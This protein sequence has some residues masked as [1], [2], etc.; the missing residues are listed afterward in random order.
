MASLRWVRF[1]RSAAYTSRRWGVA[2]V[3][4]AFALPVILLFAMASVELATY[5]NTLQSLQ[6]AARSLATRISLLSDGDPSMSTHAI[7]AAETA[8]IHD[9]L[10]TQSGGVEIAIAFDNFVSGT[11]SIRIV[12]VEASTVYSSVVLP[13]LGGTVRQQVA[14]PMVSNRH[15]SEH[16]SLDEVSQ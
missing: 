16:G 7:A 9:L 2:T 12:R 1:H 13:F 5:I 15:A 10:N 3:E 8:A 4:L 6:S 11:G 14:M